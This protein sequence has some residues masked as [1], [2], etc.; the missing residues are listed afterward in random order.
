MNLVVLFLVLLGAIGVTAIAQRKGFQPA[1]VIVVV[2]F[3]VSFIPGFPQ[4][5]LS[6]EVILGV[7]LPPLLYSAALNFSFFS[8]IRNLRPI[9]GL[10]VGLVIV[11]ALV[12]G[13]VASWALPA[14]TFGTALL[15][16]AI[17]APPDAV[18]A[19]AIGQKLGLPKRVMAILTGESLVNDAAALTLFTI[20]VASIA[21]THTLFES[22][23]LLFLYAATVGVVI[24]LVLGFVAQ[25]IRRFLK[26]SGLETVLGLMLPF[27]AYFIA[28][29]LEG[30]GVLA[31]V[32][33]GFV[34]GTKS[35]KFRYETR[36]QE[37]QV[38]NSVD[39]VLEAFVF[40]Y[41]G[42]Q[43]RSIITGIIDSDTPWINVAA[44][45]AFVLVV[46]MAVRPIWVFV[47]FGRGQ[48]RIRRT[49]RRQASDPN[50]RTRNDRRN[51]HRAAKGKA[52][53]PPRQP[54]TI[55]ESIV[56][57]WTGMRG[58]VTI[59]AA[60]G[61]PLLT[62]TGESFPARAEIQ[63]I[64]FVVAVGTL[65][66]QGL[67]LPALIRRVKLDT[68]ADEAFDRAEAKKAA[69][70]ARKAAYRVLTEIQQDPPAGVSPELIAKVEKNVRRQADDTD[71]LAVEESRKKFTVLFDDIHQ[72]VLQAQRDDIV[73]ARNAGEL[74]DDAAMAMIERL[75]YQ[76]AAV[77][78]RSANRLS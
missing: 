15:L 59:A 74:D 60:S 43:L 17:V 29:Q 13:G 16:G 27:A 6:S 8:F 20:T 65:L 54:L 5:E 30:S 24:G 23:V 28:E 56:V 31:V 71:N 2:G 25:L 52:P 38:W 44:A 70:V 51:E 53:L 55:A 12:V 64:A 40:A 4:L 47:M 18:T 57:S 39:V 50:Y 48:L 78:A 73:A 26:D 37:R 35:T 42:L 19:V 75:D 11:T 61:I 69:E 41:M 77:V 3:A 63:V 7:V 10:G 66:I 36:L 21:G 58:V 68:T 32:M 67:T 45:S 72:R 14:F 76:E 46:V 34:M 62:A 22:P 33:A 1:L 9:L 49:A